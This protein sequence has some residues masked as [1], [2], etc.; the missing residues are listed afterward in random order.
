M[1]CDRNTIRLAHD[2]WAEHLKK[3][4][5]CVDATAGR[6]KDTLLLCEMVG[7]EGKVYSFDIQEDA[8]ASTRELLQKEEKEATLILDSHANL[9]TY[10]TSCKCVVFNLGYLPGGD[11]TIGTCAT[12]S[13]EAISAALRII[14]AD[15]FVS[16]CIYYG[17]DSGFEEKEAVMDFLKSLDF[18]TYTV[19]VHDFYNRPNCPPIF[20]VIEKNKEK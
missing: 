4:D 6:G 18:R 13:I 17:G 7:T 9:E 3:G 12:S 15:G 20:A 5:I 1:Y 10:L 16:I 11:H 8:I 2:Y 14:D 19:M